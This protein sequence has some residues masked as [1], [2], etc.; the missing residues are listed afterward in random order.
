KVVVGDFD[1][2][3][4][5]EVAFSHSERAGHEVAWYRSTTPRVDGAWT[6]H[7]VAMV[8]FCHTLQAADWDLDGDVD[9]L[10]GGMT[11]SQHRG[12]R[13]L[14]NDG[15]GTSWKEF[16]IQDKGSYS[17]EAGDIDNDGDL[18]IVGIRNWNKAPTYLYRNQA[19][20]G[21]RSNTWSYHPISNA[22]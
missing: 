11:Q 10:V 12:L 14:F 7:V 4:R 22:H 20:Q 17:A 6:R 15:K 19:R 8:D 2:D 1:G 13:L 18:D 16:V 5:N 21:S 3:H 9:L